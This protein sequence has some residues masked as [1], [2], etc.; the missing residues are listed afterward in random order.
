MNCEMSVATIKVS[1]C[2]PY[3]LNRLCR[4]VTFQHYFAIRFD[5]KMKTV[6]IRGLIVSLVT[7]VYSFTLLGPC[8]TAAQLPPPPPPREVISCEQCA[9]PSLDRG[10]G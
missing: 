3:N 9:P 6:L 10:R 8:I 7:F 5:F 4:N 1:S 2:G